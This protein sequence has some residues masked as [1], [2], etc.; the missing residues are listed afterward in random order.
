MH[1]TNNIH[2]HVSSQEQNNKGSNRLIKFNLP[3]K[4]WKIGDN[5]YFWDLHFLLVYI[6]HLFINIGK[7]HIR[8]QLRHIDSDMILHAMKTT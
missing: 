8:P 6:Y 2:V 3:Y 4:K 1:N 7:V 5:T